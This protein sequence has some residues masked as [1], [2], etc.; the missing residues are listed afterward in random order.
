MSDT[1]RS[2]PPPRCT[3]RA[4]AVAWSS[5]CRRAIAPRVRSARARRCSTRCGAPRRRRR[6]AGSRSAPP[7]SGCRSISG[8]SGPGGRVHGHRRPASQRRHAALR[9]FPAPGRRMR[10]GGAAGRATCRPA[11]ARMEQAAAAV[12]ELVAGIEL[13]ENRYTDLAQV[14][15]PTMIG[16]QVY[17]AA[18]VSA[19]RAAATGASWTSRRCAGG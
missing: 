16:D 13:V 19:N 15:T 10:A 2:A 14:G 17:H 1:I 7:P 6:R 3:R 8:L 9:R 5:R 4:R 11:P 18:A 12:G